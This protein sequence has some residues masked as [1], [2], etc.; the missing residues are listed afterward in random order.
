MAIDLV[1]RVPEW[2]AQAE[3]YERKAQA[4]RQIVAG[5]RA[6]NGEAQIILGSPVPNAAPDIVRPRGRTAV[7][8]LLAEREPGVDWQLAEIKRILIEREWAPSEK[9]VEVA[10]K[11]T[12]SDGNVEPVGHDRSG[13]Y[14]LVVGRV[15]DDSNLPIGDRRGMPGREEAEGGGPE[16]VP[17]APSAITKRP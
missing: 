5:V 16:I 1:T 13:I 11:R 6:L 12:V 17:P 10:V 7:L 4:L 8:E 14:R 9:A 3:E 15:M 2:E